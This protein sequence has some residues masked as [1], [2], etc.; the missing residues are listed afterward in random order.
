MEPSS[1]AGTLV[2]D[3]CEVKT[4]V[5]AYSENSSTRAAR[6]IRIPVNLNEAKLLSAIQVGLADF[7]I[8]QEDLGHTTLTERLKKLLK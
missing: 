8:E 2:H 6:S 3:I 5:Q 4:T 1:P 7:S